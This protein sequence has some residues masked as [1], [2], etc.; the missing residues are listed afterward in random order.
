MQ[1][2]NV[3]AGNNNVAF[4]PIF[5]N[6]D[7][8]NYL[9]TVY[10]PMIDGGTS[11]AV[12]DSLDAAG[13][14]RILSA[15][16]DI[17]AYESGWSSNPVY[18]TSLPDSTAACRSGTAVFSVSGT[19]GAVFQWQVSSNGGFFNIP[20]NDGHH[21]VV[22]AGGTSTLIV[23][24]LDEGMNGYQYGI[25]APTNFFS[26][27]ATL[28]VTPRSVIYVKADAAGSNS[29]ASWNNAFTNLQSAFTVADSCS[30]IWVAS[31]TYVPTVSADG[32]LSFSLKPGLTVYGGFSGTETNR[33]QRNWT[34]NISL[35]KGT[36]SAAVVYNVV[37]SGRPSIDRS[38]VLDGFTIT[39]QNAKGGV[40]N[41]GASPTIR[42][43][44]F[45][46]N[47]GNPIY[48]VSSARPLIESCAFMGNS[49]SV[50][51]SYQ[52]SPTI[53]NCVF[54]GNSTTFGA[55]LNVNCSATIL[56]STFAFNTGAYNGAAIDA[57]YQS[58][59]FISGCIFTNNSTALGSGGAVAVEVSGTATLKNC[60]MWGNSALYGGGVGNY[61]NL[62]VVNCTI[63]GNTA[64]NDGSGLYGQG[65][66]VSIYN[67]ILSH[68]TP[69]SGSGANVERAQIF[70][71]SGTPI[72]RHCAIHGLN[73]YAGNGNVGYDPLLIDPNAGNWNLSVNSPMINAGTNS[74]VDTTTDVNGGARI[75]NGT[76]DI[77]A[78]E[79]T[80]YT[81]A[82]YIFSTPKSQTV[83]EGGSASF[84][85]VGGPGELFRW[86]YNSGSGWQQV[87][88]LTNHVVTTG[89]GTSTL[90]INNTTPAMNGYLYRAVHL[91]SSYVSA[92][93]TLK[94]QAAGIIYV[95]ATA[96][97]GGNGS[98]WA[99]A[100]RDLSMALGASHFCSRSIWVA[101]GTYTGAV[102][103]NDLAI[104]A[105]M[106]LF[107]GFNGTETNLTQ[108]EIQ[109]NPTIL[110]GQNASTFIVVNGTSTAI[111]ADTVVD[112]FVVQNAQQAFGIYL[113]SPTIRNCT[114]R[115]NTR[116]GIYS[117]NS[118]PTIE[119]CR[120][121]NNSGSLG[122]AIF[123]STYNAAATTPKITSCEFRGNSATSAGG[124]IASEFSNPQIVN[125]L[126]S[127]NYA[128]N[129][130]GGL[131]FNGGSAQLV[132]CTIAGNYKIG[133]SSFNC[134]LSIKN[135][136]LWHNESV[137]G[138]TEQKQLYA[139]S[140]TV[141]IQNSA[142]QSLTTY[143]GNGN[144]SS[145]PLFLAPLT[146][147]TATTNGDWHVVACS[148]L[149]NAGNSS[150]LTNV[151]VDLDGSPRVVNAIDIG[152][153]EF[154][155]ASAPVLAVTQNPV[156]ITYCGT[157]TNRFSVQATGTNLTYR[158]ELQS[159][160]ASTFSS[161]T[162]DATFVGTATSTLNVTNAT[163][164]LNGAQFRCLITSD[165][166]CTTRSASAT[167]TVQ[168]SRLYVNASAVAGGSGTS[169][170][171]A[172]T[173]LHQALSSPLLDVC[174][175]EIWVAAGLYKRPTGTTWSLKNNVAIYGGFSGSETNLSQRDWLNNET[176]L[177][178]T[179]NDGFTD[180]FNNSPAMNS[181]AR[182]DGFTV[183]GARFG[184]SGSG[185]APTLVNCT[186]RNHSGSGIHVMQG[187]VN[188][189]QNCRFEQNAVAIDI[190]GSGTAFTAITAQNCLFQQNTQ[191]INAVQN[192]SSS[193]T[194]Q[195]CTFG[196]NGSANVIQ[197]QNSLSIS[198]SVFTNNV[199]KVVSVNS[200]TVTIT[201][202]TFR[203]NSGGSPVWATGTTTMSVF[204]SLFSGNQ[205][206]STASAIQTETT[207]TLKIYGCT[208]TGNK[209]GSAAAIF[210]PISNGLSI[211][212]SIAWNNL[213]GATNTTEGAQV[214]DSSYSVTDARNNC[215]Q[216]ANLT[217]KFH[218]NNGNINGDPLFLQVIIASNAPTSAGIFGVMPCSP[219]IDSGNNAYSTNAFDLSGSARKIGGIVDM[220]AYEHPGTFAGAFVVTSHPSDAIGNANYSA[221][222]VVTANRSADVYQWQRSQ[223]GGDFFNIVD[224][225][226]FIGTASSTLFVSNATASMNGDRFRCYLLSPEGCEIYSRPA[227]FT[228][229]TTLGEA[230][231]QTQRFWYTG[232]RP[233]YS[234]TNVSHD[235]VMSAASGYA[236][237]TGQPGGEWWM[238]TSATGPA[239]VSFWWKVNSYWFTEYLEFYVDGV[240]QPGRI[241]G[242]VD[243]EY[244]T[245]TIG[246]GTHQLRW[247]FTNQSTPAT[248]R[249]FVDQVA[250]VPDPGFISE[251]VSQSV[252]EGDNVTFSA[253][254]YSA[255]PLS[256]QWRFNNVDIGSAT[257]STYT[258]NNV[259]VSQ[260]GD[261]AVTISNAIGSVTS[262]NAALT[263][264]PSV[265]L[266][267]ALDTTHLTW[268]TGGNT[269][270][271][272]RTEVALD[273]IDAARSGY[274]THGQETWIETTANGPGNLGFSW[275]VSS[276][277]NGD[278]LEFYLDGIL[279]SGRISG[280]VDWQ[281]QLF[282]LTAG[283]HTFRWRYV[284]NGSVSSGQDRA[285]VDQVGISDPVIVVQP[286]GKTVY[287]G[288]S[289]TFSVT[290]AGSPPLSYQW[291][292]DGNNIAAATNSS[293]NINSVQFADSGTYSV[294]VSN[295]NS[296]VI[297]SPAPLTVLTPIALAT[298]LD[299]TN[300]VWTTGGTR[301]WFGY[302]N[303][304]HDGIDAA[305]S[306]YI[307]DNEES[308]IQASVSGPATMSFWWRVSSETG[309]DLL[310]FSVNG[311]MR[312]SISGESGWQKISLNLVAGSHTLR[313]RYAKNSS[314]GVG[315]DRAWLDEV[316]Y[317][318]ATSI[319]LTTLT[320]GGPGSLRQAIVDANAYPAF[321]IIDATALN[322]TI[323][324]TNALPIITNT[325]LITGSGATNLI[326]SG[327][328]LYRP[329]FIHA[330]SLSVGISEL[331]IANG[332]AKGGNGGNRAGGGAGMGGALF[333]NAGDISLSG[334]QFS[335]NI[336][337]GGNGG[338]SGSSIAGAGGGGGLG[339]D[340]ANGATGGNNG[341]GG[342][343]GF[344][345]NGG[346]GGSNGGGG[347]GGGVI[348]FGGAGDQSGGGG[349]GNLAGQ[350]ASGGT[351]GTG[352]GGGGNGGIANSSAPAAGNSYG[353][354]GGGG[355]GF[356]TTV[357]RGGNG[358][359]FGG[360]G[361]G[362]YYYGSGGN[363]GDFGGGG[364]AS[365]G[366]GADVEFGRATGGFGAGGGGGSYY[367]WNFPGGNGGF[368]GGGGGGPSNIRF[369]SSTAFGGNGGFGSGGGGGGGG[370]ALGGAIF[371]RSANGASVTLTDC[372]VDAGTL[373][374]GSGGA[375]GGSSA[376]GNGQTSGDSLFLYGG[377]NVFN[378][379][380]GR[381]QTIAGSIGGWNGATAGVSKQGSGTLVL[382][383]ASSYSGGT[384]L[385]AGTLQVDGN[386]TSS[387]AFIVNSGSAVSGA[388]TVGAMTVNG[389]TISPGGAIGI[390]NA[391]GTTCSGAV[392]LNWQL[393]DATGAAGS[394]FD[395]F[396]VN[397]VLD[398]SSFSTFNINLWTLS[399]VS[400]VTSGSAINFNNSVARSWTIVQT[401][402]GIVGF[403]ASKFNVITGA[404]NGTAGFANAIGGYFT[405]SISG[406]NLLL[407]YN[408][409][410]APVITNPSVSAITATNATLNASVNPGG[411]TASVYFQYGTTTSYGSFTTT[412]IISGNTSQLVSALAAGLV[413]G[414]TYHY[415]AV[416]V[417][418]VNT[419]FGSDQTFTTANTAPVA[420]AQTTS[421]SEDTA[422]SVTLSGSDADGDSLTYT[423]IDPPSH[424]SLNGTPPNV[425]Y[426]PATNYFGGDSFIFRA[427]D[428]LSNSAPAT[429]SIT[430]N[431]VN[432][433]PVA[434]SQSVTNHANVAF[435]ITMSGFDV[436]GNALTFFIVTNP[437]HGAISGTL[438]DITYTPQT[439]YVG[440]DSFS[441]VSNDGSTNSAP[442]T[443]SITVLQSLRAV[444]AKVGSNI[445]LQFTGIPGKTYQVQSTTNLSAGWTTLGTPTEVSPGTYEYQDVNP[446]TATRY[447][448]LVFP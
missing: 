118:N 92:P 355:Y 117:Y 413:R 11:S 46:N 181:S 315:L 346:A 173:N 372:S 319:V 245:Y 262:T 98:S 202:C 281:Q 431:A 216:N 231:N 93:A 348:G 203:A 286:T 293:Y 153:L 97:P 101:K 418:T 207:G 396:V 26:P 301:P 134:N 251:P 435:S 212:N 230:V 363:G 271:F 420:N 225:N 62:T 332:R 325:M 331:T 205:S 364:G 12:V 300:I 292:R 409:A 178:V 56:N 169:W 164:A 428:G 305:R 136:V 350:N 25:Y 183:S 81:T 138:T 411:I 395:Q 47:S 303:I 415:R 5:E 235:G 57:H 397:G 194:V 393:Y 368:G 366:D 433:A 280:E 320:D 378:V 210:C 199:G 201:R 160:L 369:G 94:V 299:R 394:G 150:A 279:Q 188:T 218:S 298:A 429:V 329:F 219:V 42:N 8:D 126:F 324:L 10:S 65:G 27:A 233:W 119:G 24:N 330:P 193:V 313:W 20:V 196:G 198:D 112:G 283:S 426:L 95:N 414:T 45:L 371:I 211:Y 385:D 37:Y 291:R 328:G 275:K 239:G 250:I 258:M 2:L 288:D 63:S 147:T 370:S 260:A 282:P 427:N 96:A 85:I 243:W 66:S 356:N 107:G 64:G 175:S 120:F 388:G 302:T 167:L 277:A 340:G 163:T 417:N 342:G 436:E 408:P 109:A 410:S 70:V 323:T 399:S 161:L 376:G 236:T 351:A 41:S 89:N 445:H 387:S 416:A 318:P 223:G 347:G 314:N 423:I 187:T 421:T 274:I 358:G 276:E 222:F 335:N 448:R 142:V 398:L 412:N 145:N 125:C 295:T 133:V 248:S 200:G 406:N 180:V 247:R 362:G 341:G 127:G 327:A 213:L 137:S 84:Q 391:G 9:L 111:G 182:L 60:V 392:N 48:N 105:G 317:T 114:I 28:T 190:S 265:P 55:I 424:G 289:V 104:P 296:V 254:G 30:E 311:A 270:W 75:L 437:V 88:S 334:I 51:N 229:G 165:A 177:T 35:L 87:G 379:S 441:F 76:V 90:T 367:A 261:Y 135:S 375:G 308:W 206:T 269:R 99:I 249:A 86:D 159:P 256:Y 309:A 13:Q 344:A 39:D 326:V 49:D 312:N 380:N 106:Q 224:G 139:P 132:N 79:A 255:L 34:N 1:G 19:D 31:G 354:G 407:N 121:F 123:I 102:N 287:A 128:P 166:G 50:Y 113:A 383:G 336:A 72:L 359:Q 333:A 217:G 69:T 377:T 204:D 264:A 67:T 115:N 131:N 149:I 151:T 252:I 53:T 15:A 108:R 4:D 306:G 16:V 442:A 227:T 100:Y 36:T 322:G 157:A 146:T 419:T 405:V 228:Y 440:A 174:G 172:F 434:N 446:A 124:A 74:V 242:E 176:V 80:N 29:G 59:V 267:V 140:G 7:A 382:A 52:A 246:A 58:D 143:V 343:G 130:G 438:P 192:G 168:P 162:D 40:F 238:E 77:G 259:L 43:C 156:S 3:F 285:W 374:P 14:P 17:G 158:W 307:G 294:T 447:Y 110:D 384:I 253:N 349:G 189:M 148:P 352:S 54:K 373:T 345:G 170:T 208:I 425:I 361:G 155:S 191:A 263:V 91:S 33:S 32:F 197:A 390:L 321:A 141:S 152:A 61:G 71:Q 116:T 83:C 316:S 365:S 444:V 430:V 195:S 268:T 214:W 185:G 38:A 232:P 103:G 278:Y 304:T 6:P 337:I 129:D 68:N 273:T 338:A 221:Q 443:V 241:T 400:P 234:E 339:G 82:V 226:N 404:N 402:G 353:G 209:S 78:S 122:A 272:G 22:V 171:T 357:T 179:T 220:G 257:A 389:G 144:I 73:T 237:N 266:P 432:D 290:A 386:I 44:T 184:V 284:K 18:L 403:N 310:E 439:N 381:T 244:K 186:F 215:V 23:T 422:K 360:G 21:S 240:L 401:T 154:Q 297:S